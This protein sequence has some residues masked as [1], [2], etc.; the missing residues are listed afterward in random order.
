VPSSACHPGPEIGYHR[1]DSQSAAAAAAAASSR[2]PGMRGDGASAR[3][4]ELPSP[5]G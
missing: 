5:G 2:L 1:H 4:G 3:M